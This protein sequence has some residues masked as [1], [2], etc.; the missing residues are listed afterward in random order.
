MLARRRPQQPMRGR[1]TALTIPAPT[2]GWNARDALANM[3]PQDAVS[4]EN[5]FP[6]TTAVVFRLGYTQFFYG[7]SGQAET[8]MQYSS[9]TSDQFFVIAGGSIYDATAGGASGAADVT[10]LTNSRWQ[11]VNNTTA[12]GSYIQAVNGADKM[13]FYDGS[14]WHADG[15]GGAYDITG[16]DSAD[17]IGIFM[18]HNRVWLVEKDTLKAWYLAAGAIGGTANALDLSSIAEHGGYIMAGLSWTGDT[19]YGM[20]DMTLFMTSN[21][22]VIVYK[23]TDPSS[24][25]TWALVGV[26]WIGSPVGRRCL[27]KYGGDVLAICQDGV[28]PLSTIVN[29][30][31]GNN[32]TAFSNKIQNA[33]SVAISVYGA[34]FGWQLMQFPRE[35]QLYLN[36][37]VQ[38]GQSQQQFVMS[39]IPRGKGEWAW[40]N[41]TGWNA[42]CFELWQDDLYFGGDGFVGLAWNGYDDDGQNI[43]Y[44]TLQAFNDCGNDTVQKRI[45]MIRPI[46]QSNGSPSILAGVNVDFDESDPTSP[47]SFAGQTYAVW[48]VALWDTGLWGSDLSVLK[49]WQGCTGIGYWVAPR[50]KAA[51]MGIATQWINSTLV[52]EGGGII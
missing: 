10:G 17:C 46:L 35:N 1:S 13:R 48:N 15:D 12:G 3:A 9:G 11:Y 26:F 34:N 27:L 24:A 37:P 33:I 31:R 8:L 38:E 14:T 41:F 2:L 39:T 42:N 19:G 6:S 29:S 44:N 40:C 18:S 45:T 51:Q 5:M 7:F 32:K 49:N 25:T 21:G 30:V 16:V 36:V 52:F 23:G 28:V 20:D 22:E 50:L 43:N 47:L 4:M